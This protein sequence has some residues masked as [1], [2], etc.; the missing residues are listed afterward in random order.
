MSFQSD[1]EVFASGTTGKR[2]PPKRAEETGVLVG[3]GPY[4][5]A[6]FHKHFN[7]LG[8]THRSEPAGGWQIHPFVLEGGVL[9]LFLKLCGYAVPGA[10]KAYPSTD[11]ILV[12]RLACEHFP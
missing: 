10:L 5:L 8:E 1:A 12:A 3:D 4:R 11:H 7:L 6:S 2:P 9:F